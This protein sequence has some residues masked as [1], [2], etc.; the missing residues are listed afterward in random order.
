[1]RKIDKSTIL[2]TEYAS[3]VADLN[4]K[5]KEHPAYSSSKD[6]YYK[7]VLVSLL[8]CQKGLCAYTE[9][10]I[11]RSDRYSVDNF[12]QNGRYIHKNEE[13]SGFFAQLDHFESALKAK[14]GW[15]WDNFFAVSDKINTRKRTKTVDDIL[16]PDSP[17]YDPDKWLAYDDEEH[18]F[19]ANPDIE[20]ENTVN[21]IQQMINV[22]G[23]N[24]GTIK[25]TRT[26][27]LNEKM[28]LLELG[29]EKEAYQFVTAFEMIKENISK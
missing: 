14:K 2:A 7:D 13:M 20:D 10:L 15:D 18:I 22:L 28:E 1:M 24:Y 9:I 19:Y 5:H 4:N 3:W 17:D 6:G 12:D 25:D 11:A 21:R 27:Y 8:Y 16:K 26:E 29:I 23:L